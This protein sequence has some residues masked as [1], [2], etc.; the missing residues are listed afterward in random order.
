MQIELLL[1]IALSTESRLPGL[2]AASLIVST[3]LPILARS[4]ATLN[5]NTNH[6]IDKCEAADY[7]LLTSGGVLLCHAEFVCSI[8]HFE[9]VCHMNFWG[10]QVCQLEKKCYYFP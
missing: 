3:A 9:E 1:R 8:C 4:I 7:C 6:F 10:K 5:V 2:F